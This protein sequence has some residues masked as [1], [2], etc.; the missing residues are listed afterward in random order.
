[1]VCYL[2]IGKFNLLAIYSSHKD[3]SKHNIFKNSIFLVHITS[4]KTATEVTAVPIFGIQVFGGVV[5]NVIAFGVTVVSARPLATAST[6]A[7]SKA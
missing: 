4:S 3:C 1:V 2:S 6:E 7:S 5:V